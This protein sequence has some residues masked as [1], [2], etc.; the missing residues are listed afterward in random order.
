MVFQE[1]CFSQQ[2][3]SCKHLQVFNAAWIFR[4]P[5]RVPSPRSAG[6]QQYLLCKMANTSSS[7]SFASQR[8]RG[9]SGW[10]R[11][12]EPT[13]NPSACSSTRSQT[14]ALRGWPLPKDSNRGKEVFGYGEPSANRASN[15]EYGYGASVA[16][17]YREKI[18]PNPLT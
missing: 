15:I 12:R 16:S 10:R 2:E 6:T 13:P 18:I 9:G 11:P 1:H 8:T 14:P 5:T 7:T 4:K 3:Q 17:T